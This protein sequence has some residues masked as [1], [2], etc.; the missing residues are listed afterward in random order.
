MQVVTGIHHRVHK[1]QRFVCMR[2]KC[3]LTFF[4]PSCSFE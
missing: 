1:M 2:T 4:K 3:Q